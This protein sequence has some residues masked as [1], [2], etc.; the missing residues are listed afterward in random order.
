[1]PNLPGIDYNLRDHDRPSRGPRGW[2][3]ID[4][5]KNVLKTKGQIYP[6]RILIPRLRWGRSKNR[7]K[8]VPLK[9]LGLSWSLDDHPQKIFITLQLSTILNWRFK[10][11]L[12]MLEYTV[13]WLGPQSWTSN[14]FHWTTLVEAIHQS[15]PNFRTIWIQSF[16]IDSW[17][18][19]DTGK[20][21]G[22]GL[23]DLFLKI[24]FLGA[25]S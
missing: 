5:G 23:F 10:S 2:R 21:L 19:L 8:F 4:W 7:R 13:F 24:I 12:I 15:V 18:E 11:N 9:E 14:W 3:D 1:M 16:A 25:N 17:K 20:C 22:L 6:E